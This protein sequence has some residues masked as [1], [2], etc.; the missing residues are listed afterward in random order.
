MSGIKKWYEPSDLI[1]KKVVV[2]T[3]LKPVK[4]RGVESKGMILAAAND[5]EFTI[6]STLQDIED[7]A[8]IS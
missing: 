6:V 3:N 8:V 7:G 4:L 5:D 2:C 1:G